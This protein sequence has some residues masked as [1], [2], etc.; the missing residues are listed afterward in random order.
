MCP[1]RF[2]KFPL[3]DHG[4]L[5]KIVQNPPVCLAI[6]DFIPSYTLKFGF[7]HAWSTHSTIDPSQLVR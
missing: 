1:L 3:S 6:I 4:V 2:S 7:G 5:T